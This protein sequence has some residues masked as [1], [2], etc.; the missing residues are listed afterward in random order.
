MHVVQVVQVV[1]VVQ[2]QVPTSCRDSSWGSRVR[3]LL[4]AAWI[5]ENVKH[6]ASQNKVCL[7]PA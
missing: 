4:C 7:S 5:S 1:H 2:V 6:E 3:D